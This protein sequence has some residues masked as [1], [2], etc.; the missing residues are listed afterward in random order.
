MRHHS[1]RPVI[2]PISA[3]TSACHEAVTVPFPTPPRIVRLETRRGFSPRPADDLGRE[4][5]LAQMRG[6]LLKM[7]L[8]NEWDR[9]HGH[10]AS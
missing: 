1:P 9:T 2:L 3:T 8:A 4:S 10:R 7:I 6:R 5:A